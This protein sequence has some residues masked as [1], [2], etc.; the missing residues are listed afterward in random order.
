MRCLIFIFILFSGSIHA[1]SSRSRLSSALLSIE[2]G[3]YVNGS[4]QLHYLSRLAALKNKRI[5][6]KYTLGIAFM[7][8]KL[9]HMASLQFLYVVKKNNKLY[10]GKAL[11]KLVY[12]MEYLGDDN[13]FYY[14]TNNIQIKNF[15]S[16]QRGVFYYYQGLS[17][18]KKGKF[19]N[20]RIRFSKIRGGTKF[21]NKARY[22][23][24]LSYAEQGKPYQAA[25]IFRNL[26]LSRKQITD[27]NRVAALM[28]WAR[29][30]YQ[31]KKFKQ[32]IKVYRSVPRDTKFW[33]DVLLESSWAYLR[34]AKFRSSLSNFQ[35]LHSSFYNDYYQPESLI[36][37]SY[38]YLYICKYYEMEKVLDLFNAIYLP[39]LKKV[40][41]QLRIGKAY[42]SYFNAFTSSQKSSARAALPPVVVNRLMKNTEFKNHLNYLKK[43]EDER[44]QLQALPKHWIRGRI[45]RNANYILRSRITSIKK[46][47]GKLVRRVL[48]GIKKDLERISF[49]EQ[50]LRYDM[51]RGKREAVKKRIARRYVDVVQIDE[52]VSRDYYIKNGYEYWPFKNENWLDELGNYHY[53]GLHNCQ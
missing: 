43:L 26:S 11:Q 19:S 25:K 14:V 23:T 41:R 38:V 27:T 49:S 48:L 34:S 52:K 45:G 29:S 9:Y 13:L 40:K 46:Q 18:F 39:T 47:A 24:A 42:S 22:Y 44:A 37:R 10:R 30:L 15:P 51:L 28:G 21:Y 36:L 5:Q 1:A 50:Y 6:I 35:T 7:E 4:K 2:K 17:Y 53:L 12:L 32:A 8:M 33:H 31:A 3:D 20:S 16:S